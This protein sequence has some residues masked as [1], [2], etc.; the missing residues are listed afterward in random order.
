MKKYFLIWTLLAISFI[1]LISQV[2]FLES[3]NDSLYELCAIQADRLSVNTAVLANI[4]NKTICENGDMNGFEYSLALL[5]KA[6]ESYEICKKEVV[7][8]T[9]SNVLSGFW[10]EAENASAIMYDSISS[11]L[12]LKDKA[13]NATYKDNVKKSACEL[14]TYTK[15]PEDIS[16]FSTR[17]TQLKNLCESLA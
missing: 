14:A 10:S 8:A 6:P 15:T 13:L 5:I 1:Y 3:R 2:L 4:L 7:Y 9:G 16:N 11:C 17:W 12:P